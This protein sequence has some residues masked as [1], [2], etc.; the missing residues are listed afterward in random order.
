MVLIFRMVSKVRWH[1]SE[2]DSCL[3]SGIALK[4]HGEGK[5]S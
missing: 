5:S 4:D 1:Q 3:H 2:V